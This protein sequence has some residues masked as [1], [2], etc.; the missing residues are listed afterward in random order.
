LLRSG[1]NMVIPG[2][3][4]PR[5]GIHFDLASEMGLW[6]THHHAE[7]LGAEMFKRAFPDKQASYL[8]NKEL[9]ERLW[10]EAIIEQK[11][12]KVVWVLSFRGQGDQPFWIQDP[13]FDTAEKRG[14]LISQVIRRQRNMIE[15]YVDH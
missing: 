9:Y 14:Q 3:D 7:P 4:L 15:E 8:K 13:S 1:G 5:D 10:R 12:K 2:T 6:I 11:D